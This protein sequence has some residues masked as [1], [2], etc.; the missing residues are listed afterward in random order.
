MSPGPRSAWPRK[1]Q[2]LLPESLAQ[3]EICELQMHINYFRTWDLMLGAGIVVYGDKADLVQQA[4]A[5][6]RFFE[7]E[8][9]G[10]C[11]P[12]RIG[13]T[14]LAEI[15][16][17]IVA[18]RLSTTDVMAMNGDGGP[19]HDLTFAMASTAIC[20]LGTVAPNPL[21]SLLRFFPG[22]VADYQSE[23]RATI[24]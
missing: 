8:S 12:C 18:G 20:G 6:Q 3:L 15:G 14:K 13:S 2:K 7:A 16:E 5:C 11:V 10:K 4:L 1:L 19:I 9:C 24:K 23:R 17:G 21:V 22:D